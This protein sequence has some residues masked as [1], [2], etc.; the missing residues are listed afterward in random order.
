[1]VRNNQFVDE[2][3]R[4]VQTVEGVQNRLDD[5]IFNRHCNRI[6]FD[7]VKADVDTRPE[8]ELTQNT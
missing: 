1:M 3:K 8:F 7:Y 4:K 5:P 6:R 2:I